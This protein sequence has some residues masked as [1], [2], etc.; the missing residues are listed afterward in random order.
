MLLRP[1]AEVLSPQL[2]PAEQVLVASEAEGAFRAVLIH[3]AVDSESWVHRGEFPSSPQFIQPCVRLV[4]ARR[5]VCD[6]MCGKLAHRAVKA[7]SAP[8]VHWGL[9]DLGTQDSCSILRWVGG[10]CEVG[11]CISL[12]CGNDVSKDIFQSGCACLWGASV[13]V[14]VL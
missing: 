13:L 9:H 8:S 14:V 10:G 4:E 7:K 12:S 1:T 5:V 6:Q 3:W 2:L 11:P